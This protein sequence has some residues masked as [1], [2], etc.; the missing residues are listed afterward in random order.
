MDDFNDILLEGEEIL[1]SGKP[2][3]NLMK[4]LAPYWRRKLNH[5]LWIAAFAAL[6]GVLVYLGNLPNVAGM[7]QVVIGVVI[8]VI[9]LGVIFASISFLDFK[10]EAIPPQSDFY[11]ITNKRL[12]VVNAA[13]NKNQYIFPNSISYIST[14]TQNTHRTLSVA[15]GHGEGDSLLMHGLRDAE[16][17]EK[18]IVEKFSIRSDE[19]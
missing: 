7:L 8:V 19:K 13:K 15:Y 14:N 2:D 16:L 1:W 17:V 18:M 4:P 6:A 5:F 10:D 3:S 11:A 12:I 9:L